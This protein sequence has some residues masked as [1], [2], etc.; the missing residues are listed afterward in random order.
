MDKD[1]NKEMNKPVIPN[2]IGGLGNQLFIASAAYAVGK[3]HNSPV[4]LCN[5]SENSHNIF[6][7]D[8]RDTVLKGFG[9][10]IK[11][12]LHEFKGTMNEYC[13]PDFKPWNPQDLSPPIIL[14]GYYQ[15]ITHIEIYEDEIRSIVLDG[16]EGHRSQ[17]KDSCSA[18][19]FTETAFIHVRRG[20]YVEKSDFHFLQPITY[21]Q[22]A[23]A[24]IQSKAKK[25]IRSYLIFS[26]D[27]EWIEQNSFFK[28]LDGAIVVREPDELACL[29]LMS[30]CEGGAICANSTFSWWGAFLCKQSIPIC[31]PERWINANVVHLIPDGWTIL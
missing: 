31:V 29:A 23:V 2:L 1:K 6:K 26:D 21:Y 14:Y 5:E 30:L 27:P 12:P 22:K 9:E 8:Y 20:D 11:K 16:L 13:H 15:H 4:Y 24:H 7:H 18:I 28:G 25:P 10:K 17:L 19:D 3:F